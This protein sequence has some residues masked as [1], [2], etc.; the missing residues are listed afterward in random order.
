MENGLKQ[1][2]SCLIKKERKKRRPN[3]VSLFLKR[4][5]ESKF[6][7]KKIPNSPETS[8]YMETE[9]MFFPSTEI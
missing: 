6:C 2:A 9:F 4:Y 8:F 5:K 3:L 7:F 1:R